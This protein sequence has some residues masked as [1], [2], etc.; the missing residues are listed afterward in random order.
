MNF[1]IC[2]VLFSTLYIQSHAFNVTMNQSTSDAAATGFSELNG[3]SLEVA[4]NNTAVYTQYFLV[5]LYTFPFIIIIGTLSNSLTF[6]VM[7]RKRMRRQSTYF[8]MGVLAIADELVSWTTTFWLI[9]LSL[10]NKIQLYF[11]GI[12]FGMS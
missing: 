8:Y 11:K 5:E 3:T 4:N 6:M 2:I 10:V 12:T 9:W 7:R 1:F